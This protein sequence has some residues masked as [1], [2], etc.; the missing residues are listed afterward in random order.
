M[1]RKIKKQTALILALLFLLSIFAPAAVLAEDN[2]LPPEL[3]NM[4]IVGN[5]GVSI[6]LLFDD[7]ETAREKINDALEDPDV[8]LDDVLINFTRADQFFWLLTREAPTADEIADILANLTGFWDA[9]GEWVPWPLLPDIVDTAIAADD[10][11]TL[12]AA[13]V[14]ADLVDALKAEGPFTVFAPTDEAFEN[15]LADLGIT[16]D[17][18]LASEDLA[19]ILLYHVVA[20]AV[21]SGDL[22]D[23]MEVETLQGQTVTITIDDEGVFVNDAQV[24]IPDIECSNGVIHA[25][26]AVLLPDPFV[27]LEVFDVSDADELYDALTV[28]CDYDMIR[29]VDDVDGVDFDVRLLCDGLIF[30]VNGNTLT[31][32]EDYNFEVEGDNIQVLG[33]EIVLQGWGEFLVEGTEA[34]LQGLTLTTDDE[35]FYVDTGGS[36]SLTIVNCDFD[37]GDGDFYVYAYYAGA[38]VDLSLSSFEL[39]ADDFYVEADEDDQVV[40]VDISGSTFVLGDDFEID[41]DGNN[42]V[43]TVSITNSEFDVADDFEID[44]DGDDAVVTVNF[45]D[46][47]FT[48]GDDFDIYADAEGAELTV[49]IDNCD[50]DIYYRFQIDADYDDQVVTVD[51]SNS[52]FEIESCR[53]EIEAYGDNSVVTVNITDSEFVKEASCCGFEIDADGD[54]AVVNINIIDSEFMWADDFEIN[55]D[56]E[57]AVVTINISGCT[58]N[59]NDN[60]FYV[61]ADVDSGYA[62]VGD[63]SITNCTFIEVDDFEIYGDIYLENLTFGEDLYGIYLY[64]DATVNGLTFEEELED[65][66]FGFY[67]SAR[68]LNLTSDIALEGEDTE[69]IFYT[70]GYESQLRGNGNAI[71]GA[72]SA[73]TSWADNLAIFNLVFEVPF[74]IN[75][76]INLVNCTLAASAVDNANVT[77]SGTVNLNDDMTVYNNATISADR[78]PFPLA[79]GVTVRGT[80]L[81]V[82]DVSIVGADEGSNYLALYDKLQVEN[83]TLSDLNSVYIWGDATVAFKD[84]TLDTDLVYFQ[85]GATLVFGSDI[86]VTKELEIYFASEDSTLDFNGFCL[87]AD[88][89][90]TLKFSGAEGTLID[91]CLLIDPADGATFIELDGPA[92]LVPG[93]NAVYTATVLTED[94]GDPVEGVTVTFTVTPAD[95]GLGSVE[96]RERI[97]DSDGKAT[98]TLVLTNS[99]LVGAEYTVTAS[100]DDEEYMVV[101]SASDSIVVEV[102]VAMTL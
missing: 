74:E 100:I 2:G 27:D 5:V 64:G 89:D 14:E 23:G 90:E 19:D 76:D 34:Y 33:S 43:V 70:D 31:L 77:I 55:A 18:L 30:N 38:E 44:A 62:A 32:D 49:T 8:T 24:V 58:F 98:Y 3:D 94:G 7:N 52:R 68:T 6:D 50:F 73:S 99:A 96:F 93:G 82:G 29:L 61:D 92:E 66:Y 9:E 22:T 36:V 54:N 41:A 56:G 102:V 17:D 84:V 95:A 67:R 59:L 78:A 11:N 1:F 79:D 65:F 20:G 86:L 91:P 83:V 37:L 40:T 88:D 72:G 85:S 71:T 35:D 53:F 21:F 57:D 15:L 45:T 13:V 46:S 87:V 97:T 12:V 51:I 63:V 4:M 28:Q 69:I 60:D 16:A 10:F 42:A 75:D 47:E 101:E 48:V 39:A 26:D 25:I 80:L 81:G